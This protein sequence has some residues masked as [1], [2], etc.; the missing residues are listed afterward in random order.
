MIVLDQPRKVTVVESIV[1]QVVRQIQSGRLKPGDRLPS[2]RQLIEMLGVGRSSV[3]EAL[4]GLAALGLVES[5]AGQGTYIS[6]NIHLL[7]PDIENPE[8]PASLQREMRLN[9]IAARRFVE[10]HVA[11]LAA[12]QATPDEI[13]RLR[14]V[15]LE[16]QG[17]VE[18]EPNGAGYMRPHHEF[19]ITL[20]QL[21]HNP[22]Y[23]PLVDHLLRAV[24]QSLRGREFLTLADLSP[25]QIMMAEVQ[26]HAAIVDAVAAG[27]AAAA[28][29]AME[30]HMAYEEELVTRAFDASHQ[31]VKA[32]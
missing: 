7:M 21:S 23:V 6:R 18:K 8:L 27:D 25:E 29:A 20:A 22:F 26:L 16:F 4:Q 12:V 32:G 28:R 11:E 9:L 19:H 30:A 14:Q 31:R 3:R 13:A 15:F 24:P 17:A 2:E 10:T 5:R 1:E